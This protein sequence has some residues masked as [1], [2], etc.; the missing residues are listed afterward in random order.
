MHYSLASREIVAAEI[1]IMVNL[2]IS[3]E[4]FAERLSKLL[5]QAPPVKKGFL[6]VYSRN[7][8]QAN[9]GAILDK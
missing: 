3:E 5:P 7:V 6:G 2:K 8:G 4:E 9:Q 1:E